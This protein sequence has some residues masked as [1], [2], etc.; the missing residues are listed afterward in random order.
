MSSRDS[1]QQRDQSSVGECAS[2]MSPQGDGPPPGEYANFCQLTA[3]P[4]EVILE[5]GLSAEPVQDS[6]LSRRIVLSFY[7]AKRLAEA[8]ESTL[9]RHEAI[10]GA[11]QTNVQKRI[12]PGLQRPADP[13]SMF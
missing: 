6:S 9:R 7:G 13:L 1:T 12:V 2:H 8:L 3:T 10:F 5:F 4:E 11:L